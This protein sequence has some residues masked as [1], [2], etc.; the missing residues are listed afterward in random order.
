MH[1]IQRDLVVGLAC[2]PRVLQRSCS[3]VAE[4]GLYCAHVLNEVFCQGR[5]VVR[6]GP[7]Y[8]FCLNLFEH[9]SIVHSFRV[10][11]MLT[12]RKQH[13]SNNSTRPHVDFFGVALF[14]Y[15]L[16]GHVKKSSCFLNLALPPVLFSA[17]SKVDD[18]HVSA[19][20]IFSS[21]KD[22]FRL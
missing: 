1:D 4:R 10:D 18:L 14:V 16:R 17:Q 9:F 21:E 5:E 15:L 13:V 8:R 7:L 22:V 6:K 11:G 20:L 19:D 2:D 12:R 3:L